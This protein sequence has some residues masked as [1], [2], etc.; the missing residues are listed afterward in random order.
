MSEENY[1]IF[2]V[3]NRVPTEPYYCLSEWYKSTEGM[4]K[5]VVAGAGTIYTGLCDKIKFLYRMIEH[6]HI[7]TKY[8]I[9]CDSWDL[10]F[11]AKPEEILLKYFQFDAD[12]VVSAEKNCF[13][14][15]LKDEYDKLPSTSSYKYLNS[16]FI[17]GTTEAIFKTLEAMKVEEIPNDYFDGEKNVHFND[18][19]EFQKI[20]L[21]QPVKMVLDYNQV[22]SNTLHQVTLDELDFSEDAIRNKET[23][24]FPCT[25]HFNGSGKSGPCRNP[26]LKHLNLL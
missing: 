3:C 18:Q 26:I 19:F 7:K 5:L 21:Q 25:F 9:A 14:A 22:L 8:L 4:N 10:V 23:G 15:D 11:A 16:G 1:T 24:S 6:G 2:S 17:V 20:F 13:P 12:I